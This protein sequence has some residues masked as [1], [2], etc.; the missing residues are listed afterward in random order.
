MAAV[1]CKWIFVKPCELLGKAC[2][3]LGDCINA[4]CRGCGHACHAVCQGCDKACGACSRCVNSCCDGFCR[5]CDQNCGCICR[6][7]DTCCA[8]L[9]VFMQRPFASCV[10]FSCCSNA[11]PGTLALV[12]SLMAYLGVSNED[13]PGNIKLWLMVQAVICLIHILM[14]RHVFYLFQQPYD[15]SSTGKDKDIESRTTFLLCND[16]AAALYILTLIGGIGWLCIGSA[17]TT[18]APGCDLNTF[19]VLAQ[20]MSWCYLIAGFY[21][22]M[23]S[24]CCEACGCN[25]FTW[26]WRSIFDGESQGARRQQG[27]NAPP[28]QQQQRQQQAGWQQQPQQP[29]HVAA[30]VV[31]QPTVVVQAQPMVATAVPV[32][33]A[34]TSGYPTPQPAN[35]GYPTPQ[36]ANQGYPAPAAPTTV[37]DDAAFAARLQEQENQAAAASAGGGGGGGGGGGP[38]GAAP[39]ASTEQAMAAAVGKRMGRFFGMNEDKASEAAARGAAG[40]SWAFGRAQEVRVSSCGGGLWLCPPRIHLRALLMFDRA[41]ADQGWGVG[42]RSSRVGSGSKIAIRTRIE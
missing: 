4:G 28:Q 30:A 34:P 7:C 10:L 13:C 16:P 32:A 31:N 29:T 2:D 9:S 26:L 5:C 27:Y 37:D 21:V 24:F 17:W 22:F 36:P 11:L 19:V 35:Q 39:P 15:P 38:A 25:C 8:D 41:S 42:R 33:S 3:K 1:L 18:A 40:T 23:C 12:F 14:T 20:V 6:A